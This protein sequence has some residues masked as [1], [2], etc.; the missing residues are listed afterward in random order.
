MLNSKF[1]SNLF[2]WKS[3]TKNNNVN[4]SCC[5]LPAMITI[6]IKTTTLILLT[7]CLSLSL[8]LSLLCLLQLYYPNQWSAG[9]L[10][11]V[12]YYCSVAVASISNENNWLTRPK[13][14]KRKKFKHLFSCV[15][16]LKSKREN[17]QRQT[18]L[19]SDNNCG[20]QSEK[21]GFKIAWSKCTQ[22]SCV[23]CAV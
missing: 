12:I 22:V 13:H 6:I 15:L 1:K 21:W 18:A 10:S 11:I 17:S 3:A 5:P 8:S 4:F 23:I 9:L 14:G 7:F 2:I 19:K 20:W 16:L